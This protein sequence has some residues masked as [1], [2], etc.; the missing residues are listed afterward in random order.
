MNPPTIFLLQATQSKDEHPIC[1]PLSIRD[2]VLISSWFFCKEMMHKQL[3]SFCFA[4]L[5]KV[6]LSLPSLQKS[7]SLRYIC[8]NGFSHIHETMTHIKK[9]IEVG[10][11][12][13]E[14][15]NSKSEIAPIN[16]VD[17]STFRRNQVRL[18]QVTPEEIQTRL[19]K[20]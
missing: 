9:H 1:F 17:N 18:P 8:A 15:T 10:I 14:V 7:S 4:S 11:N 19:L 13:V 6:G 20:T 16:P 12:P 2:S 3:P 5:P